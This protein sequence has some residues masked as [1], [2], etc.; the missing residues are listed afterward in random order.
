MRRSRIAR[1]YAWLCLY[2]LPSW[3]AAQALTQ[4]DV[5]G[6]PSERR[7][8]IT[9]NDAA[10]GYLETN[11]DE[12]ASQL[13]QRLADGGAALAFEED[14]GYL[15]SAL[16]AL[17]I[18]TQSQIVVYSRTSVQAN[19]ISPAN[20]RALFFSDDAVVG[21]IRGAPFLEFA[22]Q[23]PGRGV[24]F[25]TLPQQRSPD[26][27]LVRS[28]DC[29]NCHVSHDSMDVPGML[30]RSLP[31][32]PNGRIYP[33]LGNFVTD[34]RTALEDRWGGWYVTGEIAGAR[35]MGNLLL[36]NPNDPDAPLSAT[37]PPLVSLG[38]RFDVRG[39]PTD[40]SDV[41]A[42]MVF[43]H[44]MHMMSL[45]AR[46][47]WD[48]RAALRH[49]DSHSDVVQTL[50]ANDARE[51]VDYMLFQGEPALPG[52]VRLASD[53]AAEFESRG[54]V[55]RQGRSLRQFDL[56]HRLMRYPCSYMIYSRAF[57]GLPAELKAA[58]YRRLW[59]ILSDRDRSHYASLSLEDRSAIIGIL[60]DTKKD[61][62]AY[63]KHSQ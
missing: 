12:A 42:L 24:V 10:S 16:K 44:Q 31:T 55:D 27:R 30:L 28:N 23:D 32:W 63:F 4:T 51:L 7:A 53:F 2:A 59:E 49:P 54:P 37:G 17:V 41:V 36:Q 22:V 6:I 46:T 1:R 39:Y 25:Y 57:D 11:T 40:K 61:L 62:P 34:D 56:K 20:P 60:M 26:P 13:N 9:F 29:L 18:S 45:I 19:R 35:H 8:L 47:G 5:A 50:L 43:D 48:A 15:R 3:A 21:Y 14:S 52:P 38:S 33:Q 58:I